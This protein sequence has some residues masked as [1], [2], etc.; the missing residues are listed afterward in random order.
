MPTCLLPLPTMYAT[1]L[2]LGM[3]WD[4]E[5]DAEGLWVLIVLM[6]MLTLTDY[7]RTIPRVGEG[8]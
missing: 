5:M 4:N 3:H 7:F 2:L 1:A 8:G 6:Y